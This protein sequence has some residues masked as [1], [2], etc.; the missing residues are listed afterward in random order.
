M[1]KKD[2][3]NILDFAGI[4]TFVV[5]T[6]LA[7]IFEFLGNSMILKFSLIF[8]TA[9]FLISVVYYSLKASVVFKKRTT[10]EPTTI[11]KQS[12]EKVGVVVKLVLLSLAFIFSTIVLIMF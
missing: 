2:V 1:N 11:E 10:E 12:N 3:L 8:W 7:V 5:A 9:G 6:A 4:L